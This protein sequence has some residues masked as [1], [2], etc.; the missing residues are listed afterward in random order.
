MNLAPWLRH[1]LESGDAVRFVVMI[2]IVEA[3]V[4][5]LMLKGKAL[6]IVTGLLPGLCL[7]LA[8]YAAI[9]RAGAEWIGL[10]LAAS[11]PVHLLDLRNRLKMARRP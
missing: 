7:A 3:G 4:V 5:T 11:L 10:W 9:N 2:V 8:L 6:P 1:W